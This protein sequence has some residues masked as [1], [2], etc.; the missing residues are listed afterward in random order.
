MAV[1]KTRACATSAIRQNRMRRRGRWGSLGGGAGPREVDDKVPPG[2]M[3][4]RSWS[5]ARPA[6]RC[7]AGLA[8]DASAICLRC[9]GIGC[10]QI[11]PG[12]CR[13]GVIAGAGKWFFCLGPAHVRPGWMRLGHRVL[14]AGLRRS[15]GSA[16]SVR[17]CPCDGPPGCLCARTYS[18]QGRCGEC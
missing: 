5:P 11:V 4:G 3:A 17:G 6:G 14:R 8:G 9:A 13:Y 18:G 12:P 7:R 2:Y 1:H 10:R 15:G 16:D